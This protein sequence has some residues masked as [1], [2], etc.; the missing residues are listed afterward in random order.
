M[1]RLSHSLRLQ[2]IRALVAGRSMRT[3]CHETGAARATVLKFLL[4]IGDACSDYQNRHFVQLRCPAVECNAIWSW[5]GCSERTLP[6][7]ER[8]L[9]RVDVWTWTALCTDSRLVACWHVGG[10]NADSAVAFVEDLL[11]RLAKRVHATADDQRVYLS[12][13]D[14]ATGWN[15]VNFATLVKLYGQSPDGRLNV[16][17][18][19]S[20]TM[21]MRF[22][23]S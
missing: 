1:N 14:Q 13:V 12:A 19:E 15:G 11:S 7:T 6:V 16:E 18:L 3:I 22:R 2:I 21:R 9:G 10:R 23:R 20:F 5:V 4:E 17:T 8:R